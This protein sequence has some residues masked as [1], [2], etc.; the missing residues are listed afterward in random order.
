MKIF[1]PL[2]YVVAAIMALATTFAS[3]QQ[4][5]R[6]Y[7]FCVSCTAPI[8]TYVCTVGAGDPDPG[9]RVW[10]GF[11]GEK[12]R[13]SGVHQS[14]QATALTDACK[15]SRVYVYRGLVADRQQA[16]NL[17]SDQPERRSEAATGIVARA[18]QSLRRTG[19][20]IDE[21][22]R[23]VGRSVVDGVDVAGEGVE[24]VNDAIVDS[25]ETVNDAIVDSAK[26]VG[27]NVKKGYDCIVSLGRSC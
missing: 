6:N 9:K 12:V 2:V 10:A 24:T 18:T 26:S 21:G 11:C 4:K 5:P 7:D 22:A 27:R 14:C 1:R 8:A 16:D 19:R 15:P 23:A 20:Q 17:L 25:A 3:A 13:Q